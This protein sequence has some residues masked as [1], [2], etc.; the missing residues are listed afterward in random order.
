MPVHNKSLELVQRSIFSPSFLGG[1]GIEKFSEQMRLVN[2]NV[3]DPRMLLLSHTC[4]TVRWPFPGSS[5]E[6]EV[7]TE[8]SY[9]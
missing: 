2:L 4:C 9:E 3:V 5:V 6:F 8:D 7:M 1:G